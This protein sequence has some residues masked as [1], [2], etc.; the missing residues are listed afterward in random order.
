M[1]GWK[2]YAGLLSRDGDDLE[3]TLDVVQET[4]VLASLWDGEDVWVPSRYHKKSPLVYVFGTSVGKIYVIFHLITYPSI[5]L[6]R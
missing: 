6:G 3:A 1:L 4:E 5:Q 2:T